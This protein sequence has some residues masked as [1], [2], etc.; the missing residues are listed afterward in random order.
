MPTC[1]SVFS[2]NALQ[3]VVTGSAAAGWD[4]SLVVGDGGEDLELCLEL[5]VDRHDGGDVTASVAVVGG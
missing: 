1:V 2:F 3:E 4:V 5:L